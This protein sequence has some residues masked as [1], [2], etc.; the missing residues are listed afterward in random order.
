MGL[1]GTAK[2]S[3]E[4]RRV[5]RDIETRSSGRSLENR[6][7]IEVN[8]YFHIIGENETLE[9]GHISVE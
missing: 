5:A 8:V 4:Q 1:C 6:A 7:G 9:G 2:P 3:D